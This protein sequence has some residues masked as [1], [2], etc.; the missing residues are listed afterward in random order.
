MLFL[1]KFVFVSKNKKGLKQKQKGGMALVYGHNDHIYLGIGNL[2]RGH[3]K[4]KK[5]IENSCFCLFLFLT[6]MTCQV[7]GHNYWAVPK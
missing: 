4:I 2:I 1:L 3:L 6:L 5:K 7:L